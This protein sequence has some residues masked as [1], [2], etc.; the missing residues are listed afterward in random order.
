MR[1]YDL[2]D[3]KSDLNYYDEEEYIYNHNY[4]SQ[5][6]TDIEILKILT[7]SESIVDSL[8]VPLYK[9]FK[10]FSTMLE[11]EEIIRYAY[12]A[13][14]KCG[15]NLSDL[16][17]TILQLS[18]MARKEIQGTSE[19]YYPT[20]K[21]KISINSKTDNFYDIAYM[22]MIDNTKE[23]KMLASDLSRSELN[24][25][26]EPILTYW[27]GVTLLKIFVYVSYLEKLDDKFLTILK[28]AKREFQN[29]ED[30][31]IN[32]YDIFAQSHSD[33]SIDIYK[34]LI[35]IWLLKN[36]D[37]RVNYEEMVKLP[38]EIASQSEFEIIKYYE[39]NINL[40]PTDAETFVK[41]VV[42]KD[43]KDCTDLRAFLRLLN[44]LFMYRKTLII[45]KNKYEL[46]NSTT[47]TKKHI[48][49][50]DIDL[51]SGTQFEIY[52]GKLLSKLGYKTQITKAS[53]DQGV[54]I[55]AVKNG[56][57]IAIQTKCYHNAV[58][59]KAVQEA[60]AG[61][62]FYNADKCMVI[63]NSYFT[64]SARELAKAAGVILWDRTI[65]REK[66]EL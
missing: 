27:Y 21:I 11:F 39:K 6:N 65:L 3:R 10:E 20:L 43:L 9:T 28:N 32:T 54:D 55:I 63:T 51:L 29:Y 13:F 60:I 42:Y 19:C 30:I 4:A 24:S 2:F 41:A 59:N 52:V 12:G 64:K 15:A 58:G 45:A 37:D 48:D 1:W 31:V 16:K 62:K 47:R 8:I 34:E 44:S 53:G 38:T 46:L 57:K 7:D 26:M 66:I 5:E 17:H 36:N 14:C 49:I 56:C 22:G 33:I 61:M 35:R 18:D 23:L 50:N 40:L 25:L